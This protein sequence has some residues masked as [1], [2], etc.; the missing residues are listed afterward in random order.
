LQ[1]QM[2]ELMAKQILGPQPGAPAGPV[3]QPPAT[4]PA[5]PEPAPSLP[6]GVPPSQSAG[7]PGMVTGGLAPASMP[8]GPM[9][10]AQPPQ[11]SPGPQPGPPTL[12]S[13]PYSFQGGQRSGASGE[14]VLNDPQLRRIMYGHIMAGKPEEAMKAYQ[15][16][17]EKAQAPRLAGERTFAEKQA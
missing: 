16:A 12:A 15:S 4:P 14:A 9:P 8:S 11:P 6:A 10:G 2:G 7:L 13:S 1:Q 5:M 17:L 3:Q